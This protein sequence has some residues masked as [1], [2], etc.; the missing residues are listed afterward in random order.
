M[1]FAFKEIRPF[2]SRRLGSV[3]FRTFVR[4]DVNTCMTLFHLYI[5]T[6]GYALSFYEFITKQP[7]I[8]DEMPPPKYHVIK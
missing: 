2:L 8:T 6:I 1:K 4:G 7:N 3:T 5:G